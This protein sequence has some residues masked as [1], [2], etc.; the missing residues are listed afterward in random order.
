MFKCIFY[1]FKSNDINL[2][3]CFKISFNDNFFIIIGSKFTINKLINN[4]LINIINN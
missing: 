2:N 3:N 1:N 4:N